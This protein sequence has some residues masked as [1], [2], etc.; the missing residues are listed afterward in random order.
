MT[1]TV[2]IKFLGAAGTVTGSKY[3]IHGAGATILVD[4]GMF[5]GARNWRERNWEPPACALDK[6]DAVLLTHAHIDH[7]GI[8]PRYYAQ[9]L[10]C[11]VFATA[12]TTALSKLMLPD[13]AHLQ[14]E[15]AEYRR[16]SNRSRHSPPLPLY[17]EEDAR[18]VLQLFKDV[19]FHSRV[20]VAQGVYATWS[21]A[22]HIL[23]AASIKLEYGAKVINF[24]GDIGRYHVPILKDPEPTEFGDL[25][26][27]ESTYGDTEH[28]PE[29][30]KTGLGNIIS[31]TVKRGGIVVIPAFSVG[32]T[33]TILYYLR[34]LKSSGVIPDIPVIIDSPMATDATALYRD[35]TGDY[36]EG[37]LHILSQGTNPFTCS[38]LLFT[39]DR[40]ESIALNS[41][42]DPMVLIS[43]SGMLSGGRILHHLRNRI[44][45][46]LNTVLFVGYQPPGSRGAW[47]Q[48]GAATLRLFGEEVPIRAE[49][50]EMSN[51]SAHADRNE[52]IRWCKESRG[53]PKRVAIVHGEP[54]VAQFFKTTLQQEFNWNVSVAQYLEELIV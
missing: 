23:G 33:Q 47:I 29:D 45:S 38:K 2:K 1:N 27:I 12:A 20:Q 3:L 37:A 11:P 39:K 26:L 8:L 16:K 46:P 30:P 6:I 32:R 17:T 10:R 50:A 4:A 41:I 21:H 54:D 15:E 25:L 36:D 35:H 7:T 9:G 28:D 5:Q 51:L 40:K 18:Q 14:E 34:E 42:T 13:S 48:S 53:T 43:A 22:G 44:S 31:K 52:L 19:P 24:S 49:I